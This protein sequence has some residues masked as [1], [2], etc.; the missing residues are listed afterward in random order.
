MRLRSMTGFVALLASFVLPGPLSAHHSLGAF[1]PTVPVHVKGT[2]VRYTWA[3][4]HS[5]ILVEQKTENGGTVRWALE[6][7]ASARLLEASGFTKRSFKPGD[8]IEAC[9]FTSR[10]AVRGSTVPDDEP[11]HH[12]WLEGA[13]RVMAARLLLTEDGPKVDW[14]HFGPLEACI[15]PQELDALAHGDTR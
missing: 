15:S 12:F 1:D 8:V 6:S 10:V 4:P 11:A 7:T 14:S 13:D 5:A 2:V 9:G 3:T